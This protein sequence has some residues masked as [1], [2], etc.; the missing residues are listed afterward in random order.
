MCAADAG[1]IEPVLSTE[2]RECG[3]HA[4]HG[5]HRQA[6]PGGTVVWVAS[7]GAVHEAKRPQMWSRSRAPSDAP[8]AIGV[9][10]SRTQPCKKHPQHKV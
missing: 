10:L 3:E 1:T 2:G 4:V 6:V 5:D 7:N 8:H 9:Y